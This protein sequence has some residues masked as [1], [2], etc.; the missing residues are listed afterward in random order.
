MSPRRICFGGFASSG[1]TA[2][3]DFLKEFESVKVL[4]VEFRLLVERFGILD[5]EYSL[6]NNLNPESIDFAV[7]D[8]LWLTGNFARKSSRYGKNGLDYNYYTNGD[9]SVITENYINLISDYRYKAYSY[10][11]DFRLPWLQQ[12]EIKIIKKFYRKTQPESF[13]CTYNDHQFTHQTKLYLNKVIEAISKS[14]CTEKQTIIAL[15]NAIPLASTNGFA[16]AR[17][18]LDGPKII[19][20]DRDPRDIYL[21]LYEGRYLDNKG[22]MHRAR[23]FINFFNQ[24]RNNVYKSNLRKEILLIRLEDLCYNYAETKNRAL[25]YLNIE[26]STHLNRFSF[27][28]PDASRK[29]LRSWEKIVVNKNELD[30]IEKELKEFLWD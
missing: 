11:N 23:S 9:F 21:N 28:N 26:S 2:F 14:I 6:Q 13:Y 24:Q 20:V 25:E 7:K 19:V 1:G 12:I 10:L 18:L 4:P 29:N 17:Q 16:R 8:F 30:L 27:F 22:G 15:Q 5:L 3:G